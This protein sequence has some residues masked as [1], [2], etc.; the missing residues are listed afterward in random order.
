MSVK[1][2]TLIELVVVMIILGIAAVIAVPRVI[3]ISEEAQHA[4]VK[5]TAATLQT[6]VLQAHMVWQLKAKGQAIGDMPGFLDDSVN[7]NANGYPIESRDKK[8]PGHSVIATPNANMCGR[9]WNGLLGYNQMLDYSG[10]GHKLADGSHQ[11]YYST[12]SGVFKVASAVNGLC[13]YALM[14]DQQILIEYNTLTGKVLM[15]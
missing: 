11:F 15:K 10:A 14:A 2:F 6:S 8:S 5:M 1:G 7:F 13:S 4:S 12:A 3:F 9:L